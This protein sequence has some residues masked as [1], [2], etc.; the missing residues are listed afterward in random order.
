MTDHQHIHNDLGHT[1]NHP[2]THQLAHHHLIDHLIKVLHIDNTNKIHLIDKITQPPPNHQAII[3]KTPLLP[4]QTLLPTTLVL[5]IIILHPSKTII[6]VHHRHID[7]ATIIDQAEIIILETTELRKE[8]H[9]HIIL[10]PQ[11][12]TIDLTKPD[13]THL[14]TIQKTTKNLQTTA[15]KIRQPVD[16]ITPVI[17]PE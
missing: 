4:D 1:Q 7:Q 11:T 12:T 8:L 10:N 9:H 14:K 17:C 3:I 16:P 2:V 6:A 5:N 15:D 13:R